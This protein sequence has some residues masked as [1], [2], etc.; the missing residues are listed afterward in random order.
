MK[1][2]DNQKLTLDQWMEALNRIAS[3]AGHGRQDPDGGWREN[4]DNG[5]TPEEAWEAEWGDD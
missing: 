3:D 2:H 5:E 4:Y 1:R